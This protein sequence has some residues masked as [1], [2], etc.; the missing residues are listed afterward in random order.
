MV[1]SPTEHSPLLQKQSIPSGCCGANN[2]TGGC[3]STSSA[4]PSSTSNGDND[5]ISCQLSDQSWQAKSIAL[6]CALLLAVGSH[7][8]AHTLGAM[9]N[10]IKEVRIRDHKLTVWRATI[11]SG[12]CQHHPPGNVLVALSTHSANWNIMIVGRVLYGVG[13]GSVVIVQ[14]TILSQWFR[15]RSLAAV[16][17]LMLTVSRL[18]SFLA[19]ATVIPIS[20]WS[21]WYGYGFW[22]SALL[23]FFSL[24]INLVYIVL[25][26][27]VFPVSDVDQCRS[28]QT[29][30]RKKAFKWS[31]LLFLPHA[32]WLIVSME[33]LLGGGWGC[34]LH[35]NSELVK[36]RFGYNNSDAAATAS[37][38]QVLPIF[39]MPLLGVL[40]D[41][42]GKRPLMMV[43]SGV[44]FSLAMYLLEYTNLNPLVGM[45]SFSLSLALGPVGLVSSVP[46]LLPLSLVG[47]GLGL[48][49]CAT[50]IGASLF[51]I[52]TGWLQ[53]QDANKGYTGVMIFFIVLGAL[54]ILSGIVLWI[55]DYQIYDNLLD[56]S[57][58]LAQRREKMDTSYKKHDA[59]EERPLKMN[60][61]YG[62]ILLGLMVNSWGLFIRFIIHQ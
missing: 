54:S 39:F 9:K 49:K 36:L 42:Y 38:A 20:N 17:A 11:V 10:T 2:G 46:V 29:I 61:F 6:M 32:Y 25:L 50:N 7:F 40:V 51:D 23:C 44:T 60:Y 59:M 53:D 26:R 28:I 21:G 15:G 1:S 55:L 18:A 43:C 3:C 12:H 5:V 22:F 52:V 33:F 47:T 45:L 62:A 16:V 30:K 37:V 58:V 8:A 48:V 14:E 4:H 35:I 31:K 34:F 13:S 56:Q 24:V 57:A 27:K 19:Q 41:K